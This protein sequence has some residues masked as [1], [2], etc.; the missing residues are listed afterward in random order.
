M[1]GPFFRRV[2]Q[3][4]EEREVIMVV[5]VH[6]VRALAPG[7]ETPALPGARYQEFDPSLRELILGGRTEPPGGTGFGR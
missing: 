5:S 4:R 2:R 7:T 6:L 1:L 3:T